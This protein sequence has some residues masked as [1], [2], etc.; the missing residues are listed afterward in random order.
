MK[1]SISDEIS[2]FTGGTV[3]FNGLEYLDTTGRNNITIQTIGSGGGLAT[4][5][6]SNDL[7]TDFLL[8]DDLS[9]NYDTSKSID[10]RQ[11]N[12]LFMK[13]VVNSGGD[14]TVKFKIV[15]Q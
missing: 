8:Y 9:T 13:I 4:I 14:G 11:F 6:F 15:Q 5:Y 1:V 7:D 10:I 3:I 12:Y 2:Q